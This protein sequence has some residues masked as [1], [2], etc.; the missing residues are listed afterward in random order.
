MSPLAVALVT[1]ALI[2]LSAFFV[3]VEFASLAA[4]RHRLED[5]A[6][7]SRSARAALR[8][9]GELTV[10]LAGAQLGITACTLAL[11]A[12]TKPAVH[13]WL[14]PAF[15]SW[16]AAPWL[17]DVA[18]FVLALV[19][20]TFLHLVVG[21]MAPKSWAIGH[22]ES[23]ATLLAL[24]M[25]AFMWATRPLLRGLNEAAN[26]CLRRVGVEPSGTLATGQNPDDLRHLVEHSANVGA[27]DAAYSA[28][29]TGA[30]DL[31]TLTVADLTRPDPDPTAV[32]SGAT[33]ADVRAATRAS[34]HLRVLV[35]ARDDLVGVVHVR[36]TLLRGDDEHVDDLVRPVLTLDARTPVYEALAQMRESRQHL[37]VLRDA[38]RFAGVVTLDDLVARLFPRVAEVV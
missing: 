9:A 26:W 8:S 30:L 10:L 12:V 23:S 17:A 38:G 29:V 22:P 24:P 3:A 13:H 7:T 25:R 4:K 15:E 6:P 27:L 1:A 5:D 28:Q 19:V 14:T 32:P 31:Q 16:G 21:E 33:A 18:G 36:D 2:A 37:A 34:G 11:G 20:V 35:G